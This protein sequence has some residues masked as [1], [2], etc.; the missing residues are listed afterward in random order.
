MGHAHATVRTDHHVRGLEVS[1]TRFARWA[2]GS[3]SPAAMKTRTI[4]RRERF[5]S[6][7]QSSS[8]GP[9]TNLWQEKRRPRRCQHQI[10]RARLGAKAA[11]EPSLRAKGARGSHCPCGAHQHG[12][13]VSVCVDR[14]AAP[15][16]DDLTAARTQGVRFQDRRP[17]VT[18]R[19]EKLVDSASHVSPPG[20]L[21]QPQQGCVM[22]SAV[23]EH[24]RGCRSD[25][26]VQVAHFRELL[27]ARAGR[28]RQHEPRFA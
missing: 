15:R 8:V 28:V 24:R 19:R 6:W 18:A 17:G 10:P 16:P 22:C 7:S 20:R 11:R 4:S 25:I 5:T 13:G 27:R 23:S 2:A 12:S 26:F 9:S 1:V 14:G 3:P 21:A